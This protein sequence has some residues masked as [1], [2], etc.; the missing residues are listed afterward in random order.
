MMGVG[1]VL[2][3]LSS[4]FLWEG[5]FHDLKHIIIWSIRQSY[6]LLLTS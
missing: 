6:D 5:A 1:L 2:A 3:L 4:I